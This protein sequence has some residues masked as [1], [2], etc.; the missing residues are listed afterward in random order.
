MV[1]VRLRN[2]RLPQRILRHRLKDKK[3]EL[4]EDLS[5]TP[6]ANEEVECCAFYGDK[7]LINTQKIKFIN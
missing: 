7:L 6:F 4:C 5:R 1:H 2:K 3:Y